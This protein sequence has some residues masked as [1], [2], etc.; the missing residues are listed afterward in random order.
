MWP[1]FLEVFNKEY[2]LKTVRDQK[3]AKF[4]NLMQ[5]KMIVVEYNVKFIELS[6]YAPHIVS[7]ESHKATKFE[8]VL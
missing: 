4:L 2:F 3:I 5:G 7:T 6:C 8:A 1:R